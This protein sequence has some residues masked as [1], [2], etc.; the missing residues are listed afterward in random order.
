MVRSSLQEKCKY[1]SIKPALLS[2]YPHH[3]CS[4][5]PAGHHFVSTSIKRKSPNSWRMTADVKWPPQRN[6]KLTRPKKP[7]MLQKR[8]KEVPWSTYWLHWEFAHSASHHHHPQPKPVSN[9]SLLVHNSALNLQK[10][11]KMGLQE[12]TSHQFLSAGQK[13]NSR[14][15][16]YLY[17]IIIAARE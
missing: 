8:K 15:K 12:A 3:R 16:Q 11:N 6:K 7:S 5:I 2:T 4:D 9:I 10:V 17:C 13:W 1:P 14:E